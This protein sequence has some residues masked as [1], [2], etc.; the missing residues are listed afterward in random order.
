MGL[1]ETENL[2]Y[3][4]NWKWNIA[5]YMWQTFT[6]HLVCLDSMSVCICLALQ[7]IRT[8]A[9][10]NGNI[11]LKNVINRN[12]IMSEC[13]IQRMMASIFTACSAVDK[14][15]MPNR[16]LAIVSSFMFI[17][18]RFFLSWHSYWLK[19]SHAYETLKKTTK[20]TLQLRLDQQNGHFSSRHFLSQW[21]STHKSAL[22]VFDWN[23]REKCANLRQCSQD[24]S[25]WRSKRI[26]I[27]FTGWMYVY[28]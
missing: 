27:S 7:W 1:H 18:F 22:H 23:Y 10:H 21:P 28:S 13:V 14:N 3:F 8:I 16:M 9:L 15:I 2:W 25:E 24:T 26:C 19:K 17:L 5:N 11:H 12:L 6:L 4:S 20:R